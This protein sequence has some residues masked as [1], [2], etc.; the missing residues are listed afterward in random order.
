MPLC[1]QMLITEVLIEKVM[2]III[3]IMTDWSVKRF[4]A[5]SV[6]QSSSQKQP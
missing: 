2:I 5:K 4:P 1:F 3:I 6:M